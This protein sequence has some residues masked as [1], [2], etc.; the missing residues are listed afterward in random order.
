MTQLIQR[1][2]LI[3]NLNLTARCIIIVIL[4]QTHSRTFAELVAYIQAY[5]TAKKIKI[6]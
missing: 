4:K 5:I 6:L 2:L 1:T 3:K